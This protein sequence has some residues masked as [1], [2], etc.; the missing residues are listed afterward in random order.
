[1]KL[2]GIPNCDTVKKAR[3]FLESRG[4]AYDFHDFRKN[5]VT[6][7]ML[8]G[9]LRQIGWQKLLKKTGPTW[10]KLPDEVKAGIKDDASALALMLD[11][12]NIIKRP[13]LERDG[14]VLALGFAEQE[15]SEAV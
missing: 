8:A 1:M 9:W 13:V 2:Y 7:A 3:V 11:K 6:E 14:K 12:P 4:V 10:G 15:Y 5:G